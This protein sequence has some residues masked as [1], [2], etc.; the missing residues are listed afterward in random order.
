MSFRNADDA[1]QLILSNLDDTCKPC[2]QKASGQVCMSRFV[3]PKSCQSGETIIANGT[4]CAPCSA[5]FQCPTPGSEMTQCPDGLWSPPGS[6]SCQTCT[7]GFY[8]PNN[9]SIPIP[10][11]TGTYR[12]APA[13]TTCQQCPGGYQCPNPAVAPVACLSGTVIFFVFYFSIVYLFCF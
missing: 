11:P 1:L 2:P 3:V 7:L 8:C 10:C 5:G 12:F 6:T 4:G 9:G 13:S